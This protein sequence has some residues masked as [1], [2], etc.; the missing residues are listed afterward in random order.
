MLSSPRKWKVKAVVRRPSCRLRMIAAV[1][2]LHTAYAIASTPCDSSLVQ[3]AANPLGYRL[4]GDRCEGIYVQQ[5]S[6]APLAVVSWTQ[7]YA[8]YDLSSMRPLKIAWQ[9]T[10]SAPIR[11]RAQ[12]LRRRLY[13]RMDADGRPNSQAFTWPTDVLSALQISRSDLGIVGT[14]EYEIDGGRRQVY[15]PLRISQDVNSPQSGSYSLALLPGMELKEVFL[16]LTGP[17]GKTAVKLKDGEPV[18]YGYYPAERPIE[19][20]I[21]GI[22]NS[23]FYHLEIGATL[24]SGGVAAI[25]LWFYH[26]GS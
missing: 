10:L 9:A 15:I 7:S 26:P 6:G 8:D 16:T 2:V 3:P 13:F 17:S 4:R 18:G 14:T 5:V 12:G 20:P 22:K 11:L 19:I 23:G 1:F 24:R 25:E 21:G